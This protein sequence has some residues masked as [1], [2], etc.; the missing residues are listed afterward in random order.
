M[1]LYNKNGSVS[2]SNI[3]CDSSKAYA[4]QQ[5]DACVTCGYDSRII[6]DTNLNACQCSGNFINVGGKCY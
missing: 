1:S 6:Y 3:T 4:N 5:N 2:Q